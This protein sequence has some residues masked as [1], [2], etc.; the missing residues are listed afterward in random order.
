ME[1][2]KPHPKAL[3]FTSIDSI[4]ASSLVLLFSFYEVADHIPGVGERA[5]YFIRL[6]RHF[7]IVKNDI[8]DCWLQ[9][10]CIMVVR[11]SVGYKNGLRFGTPFKKEDNLPLTA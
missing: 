3:I 1:S 7:K 5:C 4:T 11:R 8:K 10:K 2:K 9:F 6:Y